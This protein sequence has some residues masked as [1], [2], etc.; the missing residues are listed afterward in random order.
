MQFTIP[1]VNKGNTDPFTVAK[2]GYVIIK[3]FKKPHTRGFLFEYGSGVAYNVPKTAH[4]GIT[5]HLIPL[6]HS[7]SEG[8][9][10]S[11]GT[12]SV[13]A[14]HG[15]HTTHR[16]RVGWPQRNAFQ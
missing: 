12:I 5:L 9:V 10:C 3:K 4:N 15:Y 14:G 13:I 6:I 2:N 11:C 7:H 16:N 8:I 1:Y